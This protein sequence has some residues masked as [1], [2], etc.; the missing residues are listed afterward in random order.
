MPTVRALA[1][2]SW[3]LILVPFAPRPA[4]AQ[5]P[6]ER[7]QLDS[8]RTALTA[9]ADSSALLAR[10]EQRIAAA[11]QNRE[12]PMVHLELGCIA[13]RLGE[14]TG[15]DKHYDDAAGEFEWASELRPDW[16]Y[17]WYWLGRAELA[18]GEAGLIP[19]QN[20]REVLGTD[21]LSKAARAFARAARADPSFSR[22]LVDL[23]TTALRQRIA[24]RLEVAQRALR[25]AAGTAASEQPAVL[26]VRGRVEREAGAHDSA[27]AA[28][29]AFVALGGD[30]ALGGLEIAR[31]QMAVGH[32]D[33]A[34]GSYFAAARQPV[35]D[36]ARAEFRRELGWIATSE[37]LRAFDA[38]PA[39]SLEPWLQRFWG[40]R[41][42][43]D[44][45]LPGDRL[46]EQ[47]RRYAYARRNFRLVSRHRHYDIAEVYRDTAQTEFDDRGIIY[48]RHGEPDARARHTDLDV[49]ANETWAYRRPA[50][51]GD[52]VFHFVA[53]GDVQDYKL[54]ESLL[55][56]YDFSTALALAAPSEIPTGVVGG[57]LVSRAHISPIY[58][59]LARGG[60][61][62]RSSLIAQERR[63]TQRSIQ[64]GTTTDTY[65]LR[66]D[67]DLRP[68]V[69][70]FAVAVP[71]GSELHVVF[72]IPSSALQSFLVAG[73]SAAYPVR[74]RVV[75]FDTARQV[76][77]SVDT[78][79][80]FRSASPLPSGSYLTEQV[81]VPV[82]P[83][84][85]QFHFVVEELN[86]DAGGLVPG[87]PVVAPAA[88]RGFAASDLVLGRE[89]SG[90]VWR[91]REGEVPLNPLMRFPRDGALE[92]YYELYGL[93]AA[94]SVLTHV[95][96]VPRGGRSLLG[97]LF[98]RRN[99]VRLEYT[100]QTDAPGLARVRQ[101]ID[102]GGLRPGL[103]DLELDLR[104]PVA[105]T[106]VVRRQ[107]FEITGQ[108]VP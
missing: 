18:I 68:F 36:S 78:L 23:G 73:G 65:P 64:V 104:D 1:L 87:Q 92:L 84:A 70:S 30:P 93:P 62:A 94:A 4:H 89:G 13:Y 45:R 61:V 6:A 3:G 66:F 5:S 99:G 95:S 16:P 63:Q 51:T 48:L 24:P 97:T 77:G 100:T 32:A 53:R 103:Y 7:A 90:L 49:H 57:L 82:P 22:A 56:A 107:T 47:F 54:V 26:L 20:L 98:R 44:A 52:L 29:R 86:A 33:S 50:P 27:L 31:S 91:R 39:D 25:L 19:L 75:V 85:Y 12:D 69:S 2:V 105:G 43:A 21:A 96:V 59:Q 41:D 58:E 74:F 46:V 15:A 71:G 42:V 101:R 81:V 11:R 83:G 38:T 88:D 108:R 40:R 60:T 106:Q 76:V 37:D 10:E 8:L 34:V 80:V 14:I 79:R 72:A 28:F 102:L 67:R 35:G 17:P 9:E 55:D